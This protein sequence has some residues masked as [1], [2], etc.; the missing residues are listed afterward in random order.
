MKSFSWTAFP[1]PHLEGKVVALDHGLPVVL[2]QRGRLR[3]LHLRLKLVRE[4]EL[5]AVDGRVDLDAQLQRLV[6][7]GETERETERETESGQTTQTDR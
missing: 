1:I 3:L 7:Q 2:L 6:L 5:H 4:H